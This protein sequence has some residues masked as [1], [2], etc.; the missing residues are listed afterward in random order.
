MNRSRI[1][2]LAL[3]I[4]AATTAAAQTTLGDIQG[5]VVD[6]QGSALPGVTITLASP[7]LIG[8]R[9]VVS[10]DGG[11]F[12]FLVLPPGTYAATF[13]LP[14]FQT[15]RQTNI[16]VGID[17][18]VRLEV[19]MTPA[20]SDEILVS[21]ESPLVNIADTTIGTDVPQ[22]F[23]L[24][25][26]KGRNYASVASVAPGAQ[27]DQS[28]QTFYGSSGAENAY[29]IDG[30]NTTEIYGGTQGT[31]L[32]F[33]FIDEV[34]VKTGAYSAE[35][36][37]SHGGLVNVIT[38]SGGNEFHGDVFGYYDS[39]SLRAPL[40]G[41]AEQG[42]V[43]G[44][45]KTVGVVRSDFGADLGGS[46][47]R[48]RLWFFA[49][50]DRVEDR[51]T[52]EVLDDYGEVVPGAPMGGEQFPH[53]T[54]RDL[55][56]VKLTWRPG[57]NHSLSGS[58]FGD[59]TESEGAFGSLAAP[60]T[61]YLRR[62]LTGST[63]G[64]INYDGVLGRNV[65]LSARYAR[66]H[67]KYE[68][69]GPGRDLTGFLDNSDPFGTGAFAVG[70]EGVV[71]GWSGFYESEYERQQY[72]ADVSWFVGDLA[73][74][75]E[76]KLGA[77]YEDLSVID[78]HTR[79]GPVGASVGRYNCIPGRH[80]CGEDDEHL[81]YYRHS[82]MT[83]DE[84]DPASATLEDVRKQE[85]INIPTENFAAY[86]Q[87]RWR[88]SSSLTVDLGVRWSRQKLYNSAGTLH[89][90]I[91]DNWAPRVGF[92]WDA[93]DNGRSKVFGHWG[94][95]YETIPMAIA[96]EA[97]GYTSPWVY[98]YNFSD[99]QWDIEQPPEGEAPRPARALPW[100]LYTKVDPSIRG[101]YM[102]EAVIGVEYEV[103][104]D[105]AIGLTL[106]HRSLDRI[107]E[108]ALAADGEF[109][110]GNPGEGLLTH[111]LD[112]A[113]DYALYG[114][115]PPCPDGT[116]DCH[117]HEVPKPKREFDGVQLAL[118]KR[119]SNNFQFITSLLWSRLE[120]NFDGNFNAS[121]WTLLPNWNEAF[122]FADFSVNNDGPLPNDRPWQFK[123]DGV[124]RFGFGLTTGLSTYYRS[125]MPITAMG[126]SDWYGNWVYYLSKRGAFGRSDAEW[127][128]DIHLGYPIMLGAGVELNLLLDVFNVF[129]RQ[130]ETL[131]EAVYDWN[132]NGWEDYQP[133]DWETGEP[134]PPIVPGDPLRP[135]LHPSWNTPVAW[136]DPRIV[137]LGVRL[138]F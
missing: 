102:S 69:L 45:W 56:A 50:Y 120:G 44:T 67:Q 112:F 12:R 105:Y 22:D 15:H 27:D 13:S 79:S 100:G 107:V 116:L 25:L 28:G 132:Y 55:F 134:Y 65:V 24:D 81:Y 61:Y 110:I 128:A 122:D 117:V 29:Y 101:Q 109:Y 48:D 104:P 106:I 92:V 2:V 14:G 75:H 64:A 93:L 54:T 137:R 118:T 78:I 17:T 62:V 88:I 135:P 87:D 86:L 20:F 66:H 127:E 30:T 130:G 90:D 72:N 84:I 10:G 103:A 43:Y 7:D 115:L 60:P 89:L 18:T 3:V 34:Q 108:D 4:L 70:W 63:D 68:K 95:F 5:D 124:Y 6:D 37:H 91:D 39:D 33:E 113:Y 77:E 119:F 51:D 1:A 35:Y 26:P 136:Q 123:F 38:K 16:K 114:W 58:V 31:N 76:L 125:G 32:N 46:F 129:N 131:R 19:K 59:P 23:F 36:G 11:E 49:A 94:R 74:N 8:S 96:I 9:S 126:Y 71:S 47:V 83:W 85:A 97:F 41:D 133:L 42:K 80:Y 121:T 73:G 21:G 57:A 53:D 111:N 138:S 82:F 99:D 52:K 40:S 98:T